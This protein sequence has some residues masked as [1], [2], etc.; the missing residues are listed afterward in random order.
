M[1]YQTKSMK[2]IFKQVYS[3]CHSISEFCSPLSELDALELEEEDEGASYLADLNK[4]PDYV[5]DEPVELEVSSPCCSKYKPA[6][7]C[8]YRTRTVPNQKL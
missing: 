5:D 4:V 2:P 7:S 6:L 1:Q 3:H 8:V